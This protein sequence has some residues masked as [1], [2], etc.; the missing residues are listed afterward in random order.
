MIKNDDRHHEQL[1]STQKAFVS[2]VKNTMEAMGN[3]FSDDSL[4]VFSVDTNVIMSD[5]VVHT[6]GTIEDLGKTQYENVVRER[7]TEQTEPFYDT[8][9]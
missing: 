3:P 9:S 1:P 5:D 2:N 8:I 7:I 6:V 4:A